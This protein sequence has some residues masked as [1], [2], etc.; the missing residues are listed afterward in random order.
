MVNFHT[1]SPSSRNNDNEY[2]FNPVDRMVYSTLQAPDN[3]F[4]SSIGAEVIY[5]PSIAAGNRKIIS[6]HQNDCSL[7]QNVID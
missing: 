2:W 7:T 1:N 5:N 6:Q 4:T 3:G